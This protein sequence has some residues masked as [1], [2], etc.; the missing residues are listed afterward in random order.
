MK[1]LGIA[2]ALAASL[3]LASCGQKPD[4]GCGGSKD[5]CLAEEDSNPPCTTS[6]FYFGGKAYCQDIDPYEM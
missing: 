5:D 4:Q 3:A 2:F 6:L 1:K